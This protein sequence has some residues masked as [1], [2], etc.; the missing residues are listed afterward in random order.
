MLNFALKTLQNCSQNQ[1]FTSFLTWKLAKSQKMNTTRK[2]RSSD[3]QVSN[4][5]FW[6]NRELLK[7]IKTM[8]IIELL[9]KSRIFLLKTTQIL[10]FEISVWRFCIPRF[11]SRLS[12]Q[13]FKTMD[14]CDLSTTLTRK[15]TYQTKMLVDFNM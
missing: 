2:R 4:S 12:F 11:Q 3:F 1:F 15:W 9:K 6:K 7:K 13:N 8:K 14:S 10:I 5:G